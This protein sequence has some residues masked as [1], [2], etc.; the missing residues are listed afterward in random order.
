MPKQYD[1]S[2]IRILRHDETVERFEWLHIAQ[3][4]LEYNRPVDWVE[5][6]FRACE[7][8]GVP[9]AHFVCRYLRRDGTPK[10]DG[11]EAAFRDLYLTKTSHGVGQHDQF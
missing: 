9:V 7:Q 2:C 3:L 1:A 5:R 6:G 8:A 4:A 10:H 11:V